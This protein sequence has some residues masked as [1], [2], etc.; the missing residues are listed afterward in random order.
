MRLWARLSLVMLFVMGS[1][2]AS[3]TMLGEHMYAI[4]MSPT[5]HPAQQVWYLRE[6]GKLSPFDPLNRA[7]SARMM[8]I[9]GLIS[10]SKPWL[11]ASRPELIK[12]I[13]TDYSSADLL[14]KLMAVDLKL[15]NTKEADFIFEQF[16]RVDMKSPLIKLME[17]SHQ[18]QAAP[19]PAN[20]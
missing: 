2:Y 1:L 17:Q 11:E 4:G 20:P 3:I 5:L 14:L 13:Q 8:A 7:A 12:A 16:R 15:N 6:A 19:S 10:D 9:V 18:Q